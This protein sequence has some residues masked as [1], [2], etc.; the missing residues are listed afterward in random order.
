MM[1]VARGQFP[2]GRWLKIS[3]AAVAGLAIAYCFW[4]YS[5]NI[6]F[7]HSP[8]TWW[9]DGMYARADY[10]THP[11]WFFKQVLRKGDSSSRFFAAF[12]VML[13]V[14]HAEKPKNGLPGR[15]V[16]TPVQPGLRYNQE[17][18]DLAVA[19]MRESYQKAD[20]DAHGLRA[21]VMEHVDGIMEPRMIEIMAI[22]LQD[23]DMGGTETNGAWYAIE[24]LTGKD[25]IRDFDYNP[26]KLITWLNSSQEPFVWNGQFYERKGT[27][28]TSQPSA[29]ANKPTAG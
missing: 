17:D 10:Q 21:Y 24:L 18:I 8:A 1:S 20:S 15:L 19:T 25:P 28:R 29:D 26:A 12:F 23:P 16:Y 6:R 9:T 3:L 5:N 13:S 4:P 14:E 7:R 22:A 2:M 27:A 11:P